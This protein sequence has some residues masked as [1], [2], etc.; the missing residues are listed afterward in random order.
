MPTLLFLSLLAI[1]ATIIIER[2]ILRP[3]AIREASETAYLRGVRDTI[4]HTGP[5]FPAPGRGLGAFFSP[6]RN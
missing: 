1:A 4:I 5:K 6:S 3:R 2:R